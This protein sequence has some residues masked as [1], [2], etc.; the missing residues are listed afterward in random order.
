[1]SPHQAWLDE[2]RP[3]PYVDQLLG[4][5]TWLRFHGALEREY[6]E[7]QFAQTEGLL[8]ITLVVG[9]I[10]WLLFAVL[11]HLL[12]SS[13]ERWWMT[14]VRLIVLAVLLRCG[15]LLWKGQ[16]RQQLEWMSLATIAAL[17]IGAAV[18]VAI[19]HR[20]DHN[21]P[22]EG[23]LLISMAGYFLA[24]LRL[25]QALVVSLLGVLSYGLGEYWVNYPLPRLIN[26]LLFLLSGSVVGAV[27]CYLLEYKSREN[28]LNT[29]LMELLADR[30]GLTSLHNR[31]SFNRQMVALWGQGQRDGVPLSLLIAD[32]DHFKA[33]NDAYGHHAGDHA[34]QA[35]ARLVEERA[36]R[37]LDMAVRLGG[38]EF[39]VLL[40]GSDQAVALQL[41][42]GLREELERL[43]IEHRGST[44]STVLTLS[45][46]VATL[47]PAEGLPLTQLYEQADRALY[48]AK[49][50]GRNQ[51][52]Y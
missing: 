48:L 7:A 45:V 22:Y 8:R 41:A 11:D 13:H 51:I 18:V 16:S 52:A 20:I 23:L 1:M 42:E 39:A 50:N 19:A 30:D 4:G 49:A 15:W 25:R 29:R 47:Q 21:F 46:G 28:F 34:L 12:I 26:N 24:G 36:R 5:F 9:T 27:G 3:N 10:L 38:E 43:G 40:Y 35:V 33:Y 44:S 6:R 2:V 32:V 37:P 31:R 17:G 14:G